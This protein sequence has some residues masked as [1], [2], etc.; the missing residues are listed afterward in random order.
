MSYKLSKYEA[1]EQ[2]KRLRIDGILS[3][4]PNLYPTSETRIK[5]VTEF[6]LYLENDYSGNHNGLRACTAEF[7]RH[8]WIPKYKSDWSEL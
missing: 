3:Y 1:I 8:Y 2:V 7:N 4:M 5:W 6:M